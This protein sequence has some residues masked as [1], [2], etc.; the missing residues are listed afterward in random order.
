M[1]KKGFLDGYK[2]YDAS[3]GFGNSKKWRNALHE[4]M[5]REDAEYLLK[6]D[7]D[8]PYGILGIYSDASQAEI[9]TAFRKK[10]AEWHP[11]RNQHRV[12][13]AEE[14]SKRIIAAYTLLKSD[15]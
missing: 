2:T 1:A 11:D 4:R 5:S 7:K 6:R 9:K 10:I 3:K 14:Q 12:E 8:T 13:E 15:N